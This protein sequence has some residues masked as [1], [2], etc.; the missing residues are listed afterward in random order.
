MAVVF[1]RHAVTTADREV[2]QLLWVTRVVC[3]ELGV[4]L[5]T[6]QHLITSPAKLLVA[7]TAALH[8][9]A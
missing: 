9:L 1:Q 2:I 5:E 3:K 8:R 6:W 7:A 4:T